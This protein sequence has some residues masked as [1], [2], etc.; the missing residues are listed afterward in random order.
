MLEGATWENMDLQHSLQTV[1][2]VGLK[3]FKNVGQRVTDPDP[4]VRR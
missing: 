3:N 2:G 4:D 1:G